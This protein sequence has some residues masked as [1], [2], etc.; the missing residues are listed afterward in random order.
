MALDYY[1]THNIREYA[2]NQHLTPKQPTN[3]KTKVCQSK[4]YDIFITMDCITIFCKLNTIYI[5]NH[6]TITSTKF[7]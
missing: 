1:L 4:I 3:V 5:E 7:L 2:R 6:N